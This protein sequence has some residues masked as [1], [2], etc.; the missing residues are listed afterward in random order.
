MDTERAWAAGFIDGEGSFGIQNQERRKPL[1]YLSAGQADRRVLDRLQA[2][3]GV[4]KVYGPY[5]PRKKGHSEYYYYRVTGEKVEAAAEIVWPYLSPVK[6][7]QYGGTSRRMATAPVLK[8]G[9]AQS[10]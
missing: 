1:I 4:G 9:E 6:R 2:V 8:T 3:L 7:E 5:K 10:L